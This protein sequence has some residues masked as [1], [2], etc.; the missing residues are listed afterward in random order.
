MKTISVD[1]AKRI[2][3]SLL[4][5]VERGETVLI[6]R[7]G[8]P[9]AALTPIVEHSLT[10]GVAGMRAQHQ[11]RLGGTTIRELVNEGRR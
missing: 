7:N 10:S 5:E 6:S 9:V 3:S 11:I 1:E 4:E 8:R 2:L